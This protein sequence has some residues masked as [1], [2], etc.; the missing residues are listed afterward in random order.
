[1]TFHAQDSGTIKEPE[2]REKLLQNCMAPP[3]IHLKKGA[4]VMLIKNMEDTL[5]NGSIGRVVAFMDEATF[6]HYRENE[7]DFAGDPGDASDDDKA[8]PDT[9]TG[10]LTTA[11]FEIAHTLPCAR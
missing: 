7:T 3:V 5:V 2:Y 11:K 10:C 6:D 4:Q 8:I 1:M 9:R